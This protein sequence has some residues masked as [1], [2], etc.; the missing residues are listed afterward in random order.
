[1]AASADAAVLTL[2][3]A[4]TTRPQ[5]ERATQLVASAG[6]NALGVVINAARE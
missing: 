4:R 1:M 2:D 6:V 5:A 3:M